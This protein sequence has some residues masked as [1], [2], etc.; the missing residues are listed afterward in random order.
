MAP[1]A[2]WSTA[3]SVLL[4]RLTASPRG[5]RVEGH[6][7]HA[8]QEPPRVRRV[9]PRPVYDD[10]RLDLSVSLLERSGGHDALHDRINRR[11][12]TDPD[13]DPGPADQHVL[14]IDAAQ[15]FPSMPDIT[16]NRSESHRFGRHTGYPVLSQ[17]VTT[18][19]RYRHTHGPTYV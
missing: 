5:I 4:L 10:G 8:R 3:P 13:P 6:A 12:F 11:Q 1:T 2:R 9:T 14:I 17:S 19:Q 15:D 16:I 18:A 7:A